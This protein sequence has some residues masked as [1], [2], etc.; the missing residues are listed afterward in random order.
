[1]TERILIPLD[2]SSVGEGALKYIEI[3]VS[4]LEPA[5]MPELTLFHVVSPPIPMVP[6]EGGAVSIPYSSQEEQKLKTEAM[7]YLES[8][9]ESLRHTGAKVD[10]M[11]VIGKQGVSSAASII[12]AEN[13]IKAD[14]VAMST[15]GRRGLTRWAFGSVTEKV[16]RGGTVPVLMV[17]IKKH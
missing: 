7:S 5:Q 9:A 15:H 3:L 8:A 13:E 6:V 10:C 14:L 16:L 11:V 12:Q 1:M 2:G 4:K 17:R